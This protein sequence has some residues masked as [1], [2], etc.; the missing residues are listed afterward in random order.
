[1]VESDSVNNTLAPYEVC[2]NANNAEIG[3][4][5]STMAEKWIAVYLEAATKRLASM[6]TGDLTISITDVF[7]MQ[8]TC[9]YET[10]ALGYSKFCGLFTEEEWKGFEYAIDLQFWYGCGPGQP[11]GAAQGIGYVQELVSR[12]TQTRITNFNSSVNGTIVSSNVTFPLNQPIFVDASHDTVIASILTALNFTSLTANGSLP[13][14]HIPPNQSYIVS[15]IAPFATRLVGQVLS[16]P[17]SG[18]ATH[19]RF[20]LNDAILP[21]TGIKGC[22]EDKNGLCDLSTFISSMHERIEEVDF[23][24]DCNANYTFP[25]PDN[26]TDG[27]YPP[28]LRNRKA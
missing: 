4:Q 19:I 9:A 28:S 12:L 17:A 25:N 14:D 27:R 2:P 7:E 24:F 16:C 1:M 11:T 10:V 21:M 26:I 13:T 6:I 23:A 3:G 22:K 8:L 15:Q 18:N 20:V 5:G